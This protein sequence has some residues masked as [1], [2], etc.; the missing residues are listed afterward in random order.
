MAQIP[1]LSTDGPAVETDAADGIGGEVFTKSAY[2]ALCAVKPLTSMLRTTEC[3]SCFERV[4][5]DALR[6]DP[7]PEDPIIQ[8]LHDR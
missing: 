5:C 6:K 7:N 1:G 3:K 4:G 2:F 8:P